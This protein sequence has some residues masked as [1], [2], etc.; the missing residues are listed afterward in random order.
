MRGWIGL[1]LFGHSSFLAP[2]CLL[3]SSRSPDSP[4]F[5]LSCT[6]THFDS[7]CFIIPCTSPEGPPFSTTL[8]LI[9]HN[10][11][12]QRLCIISNSK[13]HTQAH[14]LLQIQ[15]RYLLIPRKYDML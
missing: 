7:P 14:H 8:S 15:L 13:S 10:T 5:I 12:Y 4:L 6:N 11:A 1:D 3:Y 2:L 9:R